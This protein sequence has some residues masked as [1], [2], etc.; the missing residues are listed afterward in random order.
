MVLDTHS[1]LRMDGKKYRDYGI[2]FD[3]RTDS[4]LRWVLEV[5]QVY[6]IFF[7]THYHGKPGAEGLAK[8]SVQRSSKA[9]RPADVQTTV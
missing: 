8:D 1:L 3:I 7:R 9:L 2:L 5:G 4:T 6:Y